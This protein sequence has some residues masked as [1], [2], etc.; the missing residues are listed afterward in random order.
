MYYSTVTEIGGDVFNRCSNLR[1]GMF[2]GVPWEIGQYAFYGCS[3]L[4]RFAFPTIS[5]RLDTLII[6]TGHWKEIENEVRVGL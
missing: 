6:Q 4:E 5:T 2:N 1:D 3:S